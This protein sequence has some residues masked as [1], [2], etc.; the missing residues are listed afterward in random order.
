M[1]FHQL[2]TDPNALRKALFLVA[3]AAAAGALIA[4]RVREKR[5]GE[6]RVIR[7]SLDSVDS[8]AE[9]AAPP[10]EPRQ[11]EEMPQAVVPAAPAPAPVPVQPR[12][13]TPLP[14]AAALPPP[15]PET[16]TA[17]ATSVEVEPVAPEVAA[18]AEAVEAE[19]EIVSRTSYSL[20]TLQERSPILMDILRG[21]VIMLS[22]I[23]V[24]AIVLTALPQPA[25]D[26][27]AAALRPRNAPGP[28]PEKIAF[29]YLGDEVKDNQ[30]RIRGVVRNITPQPIEQLE[31]T[32]RIYSPDRTLL[33]TQV[34]HMDTDPIFPNATASFN[35]SFPNYHGQFGSYSLD[36][37][38][39]QGDLVPYKDVRETRASS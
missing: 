20:L 7:L 29:L 23:C 39:A 32:V 15:E 14:A 6:P 27:L 11:I 18:Y 16:V 33:E 26:R 25:V 1:S 34:V 35:L 13:E 8:G 3:G 12:V 21:A 19:P 31:A 37:K 9:V 17:V 36:F 28:P 30:F 24:G 38:L 4:K 10:S 5:S 22:I 2:L